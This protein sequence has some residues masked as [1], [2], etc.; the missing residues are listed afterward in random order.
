MNFTARDRVDELS[1][2]CGELA[3]R[4][5]CLCDE[6]KRIKMENEQLQ[7]QRLNDWETR[8]AAEEKLIKLNAETERLGDKECRR[9]EVDQTQR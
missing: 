8:N 2:R 6:L 3:S 7:Q 5:E 4:N 1:Q 9:G